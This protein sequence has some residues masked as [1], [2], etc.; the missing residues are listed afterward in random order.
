[1][2]EHALRDALVAAE[3]VRAEALGHVEDHHAAVRRRR[4]HQRSSPLV[5]QVEDRHLVRLPAAAALACPRADVE[6]VVVEL[7]AARRSDQLGIDWVQRER[8]ELVRLRFDL[9]QHLAR[10]DAQH[11]QRLAA[12]AHDVGGIAR[13]G[14]R[15]ASV[16]PAEPLGLLEV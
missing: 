12:R 7:A 13:D 3:D 2:E 10:L 1:M 14:D 11:R 5:R 9:Q 8:R 15:T 4:R 16:D 6:R